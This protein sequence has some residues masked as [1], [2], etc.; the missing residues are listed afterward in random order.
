MSSSRNRRILSIRTTVYNSWSVRDCTVSITCQM[1]IRDGGRRY[2]LIRYD[3]GW[4]ICKGNNRTKYVF[5][6]LY[7]G[8]D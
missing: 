2:L 5:I 6:L 1:D 7:G 4:C 3:P 8:D